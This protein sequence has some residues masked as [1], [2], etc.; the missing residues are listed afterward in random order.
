VGRLARQRLTQLGL[1]SAE[2]PFDELAPRRFF[3]RFP[4]GIYEITARTGDGT[5]LTRQVTLSHVLAAPPSGILI[6]GVPAAESCDGALPSVPAGV[7]VPIDWN[8]VTTSH[9]R[10]GAPGAI[11]IARYQFFV[12]QGTVKLGVDLPPA[13]TE[14]E[15]P[16]DLVSPGVVKFEII[17]TTTTGNNT[18]VES[19]FL[20][21]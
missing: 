11:E 6:S 2:P 4:E 9:P 16:P 7:S 21:E 1:E 15:V 17:A 18:A 3:R 20:V 14:F 10:L 8:P 12:E 5:E 13:I 19:C